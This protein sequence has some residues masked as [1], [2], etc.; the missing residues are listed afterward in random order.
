HLSLIDNN[1]KLIRENF[2]WQTGNDAG[3]TTAAE[4]ATGAFAFATGSNDAAILITL[5]PGTYTAVL[6]GAT[7]TTTGVGL[8]EVYEVP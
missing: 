8:V 4:T 5:P 6:S 3:I 7:S 2:S 1:Q